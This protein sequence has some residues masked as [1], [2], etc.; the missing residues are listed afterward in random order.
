MEK[1][2]IM[3]APS[4]R[5]ASSTSSGTNGPDVKYA[6]A[7]E[8]EK[9]YSILTQNYNKLVNSLEGVQ[10]LLSSLTNSNIYTGSDVQNIIS[11][12]NSAANL[13]SSSKEIFEVAL[14]DLKQQIEKVRA[15]ST[16]LTS[17]AIGSGTASSLSSGLVSSSTEKT[18]K[19]TTGTKTTGSI[20]TK[21]GAQGVIKHQ[22]IDGI[23]YTPGQSGTKGTKTM[24]S[25][26]GTKTT[27]SIETKTGA[28]GVIKHQRIDGIKY[29]PGKGG[30]GIL[31]FKLPRKTSK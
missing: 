2:S 19:S 18:M 8:M 24:K 4:S 23:K 17:V 29:T 21:T 16:G 13:N 1:L 5:S 30:T 6:K 27:G 25:T 26:T 28:Q 22:R 20:E 15:A 14:A 12:I 11:G 3:A 7:D 10:T 31:G 9:N